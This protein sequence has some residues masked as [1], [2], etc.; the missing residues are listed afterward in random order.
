MEGAEEILIAGEK[1]R[2]AEKDAKEHGIRLHRTVYEPLIELGHRF[3]I[4][5]LPLLGLE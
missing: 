2:R 5:D 4:G 3:G 1:E